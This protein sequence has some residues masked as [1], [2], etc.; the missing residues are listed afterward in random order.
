MTGSPRHLE[1][2]Q[3]ASAAI[4]KGKNMPTRMI[5]V[6]LLCAAAVF[7]APNLV[8]ATAV[9]Q[10]HRDN[11]QDHRHPGDNG[12]RER[13][14]HGNSANQYNGRVERERGHPDYRFRDQDRVRLRQH[15]QRNLGHVNRDHRPSFVR[16]GYLAEPYRR[17]ITPAPERVVRYLPAPPPGYSVGY[18]QGYTVVYDPVTFLI[19]DV[20]DLL[21]Q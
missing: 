19:L 18:Y 17:Y 14:P 4:G 12:N 16:G 15:Y 5:R 3:Q 20:V 7:A 21:Q 11:G 9:A 8:I 13:G 1:R 2:H 10:D 6:L